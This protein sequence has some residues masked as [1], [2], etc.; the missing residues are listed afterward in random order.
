VATITVG[1]RTRRIEP[2]TRRWCEVAPP[3][4][5]S[6]RIAP[7]LVPLS[8]VDAVAPGYSNAR[9]RFD[10]GML[11]R[12]DRGAFVIERPSALKDWRV[13]IR[14]A[15]VGSG[16]I[17]QWAGVLRAEEYAPMGRDVAPSGTQVLVA[18]GPE[19][20]LDRAPLASS[21]WED[22]A[23]ARRINMSPRFNVYSS[24]GVV[25]GN[26]SDSK[27]GS[28]YV[29]V[30]GGERWN[31]IQMLEYVLARAPIPGGF[32][33]E[34]T[35]DLET[36]ANWHPVLDTQGK[37][38]WQVVQALIDRRRGMGVRCEWYGVG[39]TVRVR[40][41]STSDISFV[42][43]GFNLKANERQVDLDVET[44]SL[45]E[46]A[47]VQVDGLPQVGLVIVRGAP[48]KVTFSL[49][50]VDDTLEA[51]WSSQRETEYKDAG[52]NI[53]GYSAASVISQGAVS[54]VIR[55]TR[56]EFAQV[57]QRFKIPDDFDWELDARTFQEPY[58]DW[59]FSTVLPATRDVELPSV[60]L[61]PEIDVEGN[62]L[63][64][65]SQPKVPRWRRIERHCGL[66]KGIDY[67]AGAEPDAVDEVMPPLVFLLGS[68]EEGNR[69]I[70]RYYEGSRP[71][72]SSWASVQ[73][74]PDDTEAALWITATPAHLIASAD[75]IPGT[76]AN[77]TVA[78]PVSNWRKMI[79]TVQMETNRHI[80]VMRRIPGTGVPGEDSEG[81]VI[82]IENA[83]L[84]WVAP[85][86]VVGVR[87]DGT[88]VRVQE[89]QGMI[90]RDDRAWLRAVAALAEAWHS[91]ARALVRVRQMSIGGLPAPGVMVRRLSRT[92]Q[93]QLIGTVIT[94]RAV[95]YIG[96]VTSIQT[97]YSEIDFQSMAGLFRGMSAAGGGGDPGGLGSGISKAVRE[98]TM[99]A[100]GQVPVRWATG[101]SGGGGGTS[102]VSEFAIATQLFGFVAG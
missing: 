88:L 4:A 63:T 43:E 36:L 19:F 68:A 89:S 29:F 90:T 94:E 56:Q 67:G 10:Y 99:R 80:D 44:G 79:A 64:S 12:A 61:L 87:E 22:E 52:T 47:Q 77:P 46:D 98:E 96:G 32:T 76:N 74:R 45:L 81:L 33:W 34:L 91:R 26:R 69:I 102:T 8:H 15:E 13:R 35:G 2:V 57:Y 60:K 84:W 1:K 21:W 30:R 55:T 5:T 7:Y 93:R 95:D 20:N 62:L 100:M 37:S 83:E 72:H 101:G 65:T 53:L 27:V 54:D 38:A 82:E 24:G 71:G 14:T 16:A 51:G 42:A 48:L 58:T 3:G 50:E 92:V 73:V 41:F 25:V 66:F 28:S 11:K 40:L 70:Q 9:V 18:L 97:A 49:T 78:S 59:E 23:T 85:G 17:T 6:W 86:T 31:A 75:F 39:S